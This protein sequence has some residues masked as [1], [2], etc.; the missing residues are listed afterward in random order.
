MAPTGKSHSEMAGSRGKH[1]REARPRRRAR[2]APA[3]AAMPLQFDWSWIAKGENHR[4]FEL[5]AGDI[6]SYA[7][8]PN[9]FTP[10]STRSGRDG[11]ADGYYN[12]SI[13]GIAGP[14]KIASATRSTLAALR[15]KI[16]DESRGA[17]RNDFRGLLFLTSFDLSPTQVRDLTRDAGKGLKKGIVWPRGK[18][19]QLLRKHPWIATQYLG[20][21]LIPGFV[22]VRCPEAEPSGQ[23]DIDLFGRQGDCAKVRDFLQSSDRVLILV[24]PGGAGKSRLVRELAS[25]ASRC[26]P[27]RSAWLRRIGQGTIETSISSGLPVATPIIVALDDA[28]QALDE[29][30][31]LARLAT[32][33]RP[34]IDV[35]VV[36]AVREVDRDAVL[37][38]LQGAR[39]RAR[40]L[41]VKEIDAEARV[42]IVDRDCPGLS[43]RD[44]NRLAKAFGVNLF[45]LRPA[46]QCIKEGRSPR[47]LVNLRHVRDMIAGRLLKE[48][49]KHLKAHAGCSPKQVL[50]D[51]AVNIPVHASKLETDPTIATLKQAGILRLVGNTLRF[52]ADVEGDVILGYLL[53]GSWAHARVQSL[54]AR[55]PHDLLARV[56]NLAAAGLDAPAQILQ[57][58]CRSW[59]GQIGV[60][61]SSTVAAALPFCAGVALR[62]TADLCRLLARSAGITTDDIGPVILAVSRFHG[63]V[64]ALELAHDVGYEAIAKGAY[65]NYKIDRIGDD[66]VDLRHVGIGGVRA[67]STL[68]E[69]WMEKTR[70]DETALSCASLIETAVVPMLRTA[71]R[72]EEVEADKIS[73]GEQPLGP[74]ADVLEMRGRALRIIEGLLSHPIK[75]LRLTGAN[76]FH[77]HVH[78]GGTIVTPEALL[79]VFAEEIERLSPTLA[80]ALSI[81]DGYEIRHIIERELFFVWATERPGHEKAGLL[82]QQAPTSA[83]YRA[84]SFVHEPW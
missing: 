15:S 51:I 18:L 26:R 63:P 61:A 36:L 64:V 11:G 49:E 83:G 80:G 17:R 20:H 70:S 82:L 45:I 48:A 55:D 79:P 81:E 46:L 71:V 43:R 34:S 66:I 56:R 54:L 7:L 84:Y 25:I 78:A 41:E 59:L 13:S 40:M 44:A 6:V 28:G 53:R 62:E 37:A 9:L 73:W 2:A 14:W 32:D 65:S 27:R 19:D 69:A 4:H 60:M 23:A 21:Q 39:L 77:Q 76:L 16:A 30:R 31:E 24:G 10:N 3:R 1:S 57:D 35:K 22:P 75:A 47:D 72:F 42:A 29:I 52:R 58:L 8:D 38:E 5:M 50:L 33:E 68:V 74:T 67:I 12:G